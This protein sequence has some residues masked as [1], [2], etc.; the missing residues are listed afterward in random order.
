[1]SSRIILSALRLEVLASTVGALLAQQP[2]GAPPAGAASQGGARGGRGGGG[3][4]AGGGPAARGG[5]PQTRV[6]LFFKEE[7]SNP[8]GVDQP[9]TQQGVSNATAPLGRIPE[10]AP[11]PR[12]VRYGF[13]FIH[14]WR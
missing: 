13:R 2:A 6:P 5:A 4:A 11:R 10:Q 1:M 14:H 8:T 3:Q 12:Q 9:L 7:W